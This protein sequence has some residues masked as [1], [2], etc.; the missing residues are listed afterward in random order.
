MRVIHPDVTLPSQASRIGLG[1]L[2]QADELYRYN[3]FGQRTFARDAEEN[4]T[5]YEYFGANDPD[6]NG[7]IDV[8]GADPTTGGYIKR[9]VEDA[10]AGPG[11]NSGQ[12]PNPV[13]RTWV[14]EYE[15]QMA[16]LFPENY[17]WL[18]R[19]RILAANSA[20]RLS[21]SLV[22]NPY[23]FQGRR[24]DRETGLYDY[25]NRYYSPWTGEFMT[26]DPHGNWAHGQGNG[27]SAFGEDGWNNDDPMGLCD[28]KS[29]PRPVPPKPTR[30]Q[31]LYQSEKL[32]VQQAMAEAK[33]NAGRSGAQGRVRSHGLSEAGKARG[34]GASVPSQAGK[35]AGK[36]AAR[37]ALKG[38][39]KRLLSGAVKVAGPVGLAYTTAELGAATGTAIRDNVTVQTDDGPKPLGEV[40]DDV[41][42]EMSVEGGGGITGYL[43]TCVV[44]NVKITKKVAAKA[45]GVRKK[46]TNYVGDKIYDAG[47]AAYTLGSAAYTLGSA[48]VSLGAVAW[49]SLPS[50]P[51]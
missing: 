8:P 12:D 42:V 30:A 14:F 19:P 11:R 6:G 18:G 48:A 36:Q 7:A 37:Q 47:S 16:G 43:A 10:Q 28:G 15:S 5:L 27:Y 50:F 44:D 3:A 32:K 41:G 24:L 4:V 25:R 39:G 35:Q 34:P 23:M 40:S 33:A 13:M 49:S 9:I 38:A 51:K 46:A 2:Q 29:A 21:E 45:D 1:S 20:T 17:S 31:A 26:P 22:G